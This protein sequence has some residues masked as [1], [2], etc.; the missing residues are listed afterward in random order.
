MKTEKS[1]LISN[2]QLLID[3]HNTQKELHAYT[4]LWTGYEALSELPENASQARSLRI[5]VIE[6]QTAATTTLSA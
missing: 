2:E 5:K 3:I 1:K 4:N 6:Y